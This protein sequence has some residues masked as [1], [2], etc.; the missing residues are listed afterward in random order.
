MTLE[1]FW[2]L[3]DNLIAS[4]DGLE[5]FE[6]ALNEHLKSLNPTDIEDFARHYAQL[7]TEANTT[8]VLEAAFIIGCGRSNDGFMD[9]RRWIVF[10]GRSAFER[11]VGDP[12]HLGDY[13]PAADPIEEWY[14]EYHPMWAYEEATGKE[15]PH[16]EV[17]VYPDAKSDYDK[18]DV[19]AKRYPKLWQRCRG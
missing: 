19:L 14:C 5:D 1:D 16:F 8:G 13:D 12:D 18:P 2:Q 10:Q 15:L 17:P 7:Q 3:V 9:F 11:I 6:D 4:T